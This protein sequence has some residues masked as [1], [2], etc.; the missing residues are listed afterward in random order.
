MKR[1]RTVNELMDKLSNFMFRKQRSEG[2][3]SPSA[4]LADSGTTDVHAAVKQERASKGVAVTDPSYAEQRY[5]FIEKRE[6]NM[7]KSY[8]DTEGFVTVGVG[9]NMDA[10][11]ARE[12]FENA[13]PGISFDAVYNGD[14]R[15]NKEQSRILFDETIGEYESI[16]DSKI[17]KI[18]M[19]SHRRI[20]LVS[21]TYNSPALIGPNL[22]AFVQ[23]GDTEGAID[24][25]LYRSN[26]NKH[27]GLQNR[28]VMEAQM[29]VGNGSP[30]SE[31]RVA[32][33]YRFDAALANKP[34]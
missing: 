2:R 6:G 28:R 5:E 32:S 10:V 9:F 4:G 17:G 22:T 31:A 7:L 34:A 20:A 25:I 8:K 13:L 23:N 1:I 18:D 30:L 29:F 15:I 33:S 14:A 26:K 3:V 27:K 21:M 24:E 19:P 12:R 16:L 11:G